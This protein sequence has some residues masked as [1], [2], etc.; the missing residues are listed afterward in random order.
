MPVRSALGCSQPPGASPTL[1]PPE[2]QLRLGLAL[3]PLPRAVRLVL[4]PLS[5]GF[6]VC[7][8]RD[9]PHLGGSPGGGWEGRQQAAASWRNRNCQVLP[10]PP[11]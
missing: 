7:S 5:W 8:A 6:L 4:W 1:G 9:R 3:S 10:A 2:T 11:C